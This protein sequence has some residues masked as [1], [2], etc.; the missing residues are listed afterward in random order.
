[1]RY[2]V[3]GTEWETDRFRLADYNRN[4]CLALAATGHDVTCVVMEPLGPDNYQEYLRFVDEYKAGVIS[5]GVDLMYFRTDVPLGCLRLPLEGSVDVV[6]GHDR[7][8]GFQALTYRD[9]FPDAVFVTIFH[10]F[11]DG[12]T[13]PD[14]HDMKEKRIEQTLEL[15]ASSDVVAVVDEPLANRL[16]TLFAEN[17]VDI[18]AEVIGTGFYGG[19]TSDLQREGVGVLASNS[20]EL[21]HLSTVAQAASLLA[22]DTQLVVKLSEWAQLEDGGSL[23]SP[24]YESEPSIKK[25]IE[26]GAQTNITARSVTEQEKQLEGLDR[27]EVLL[28][29]SNAQGLG[30]TR[31]SWKW[32]ESLN[33]EPFDT[34]QPLR[35]DANVT[36]SD[37]DLA[38]RALSVSTPILTHAGTN[39]AEF[40]RLHA[41]GLA[42]FFIVS[43][44]TPQGWAEAIQ[45]RLDESERYAYLTTELKTRLAEKVSWEQTISNLQKMVEDS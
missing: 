38:I 34:P 19:E 28:I 31:W 37:V 15:A 26:L 2:L 45:E 35:N 40:L 6:V 12:V 5:Q 13:W 36:L 23:S 43:E 17:G 32:V 27:F 18:K 22:S 11:P 16:N 10:G 1:M 33:E 7:L 9:E 41:P 21:D 39:T 24:F 20:F 4:F 25:L 29:G 30:P 3:I 14:R 44:D 42:S 8:T